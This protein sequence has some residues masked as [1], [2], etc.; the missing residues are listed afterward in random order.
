MSKN[1]SLYEILGVDKSASADE[2][3]KAYRKLARKYHPDINKDPGA[4]E[5]FKEIN[6]AYE[7]LGDEEKRRQY[8]TYGDSMFGGQNFSDFARNAGGA[9]LSDILKN[10]FG[11]AFSGGGFSRNGGFGGFNFDFGG[12]AED[13]DV[14]ANI[15]IPLYMAVNGGEREFSFNGENIKIKI[16]A[17]IGNGSKLRVKGKGKHS[18][19]GE[20]GNLILSIEI[21]KDPEYDIENDDLYKN[22]DIPLKIALFG[23][24]VDV[25]TLQKD[26]T[27]KISKNTKNGQKIRLKGYGILNPKTKIKGDLYLKVNVVLPD[28][29]KLD[30]EV[31]KILEEK[32]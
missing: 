31:V 20:V 7:V 13:L 1:E 16:P 18:S 9:D 17:G 26:V 30:S 3:K 15:K 22:I 10:I 12:F 19:R 14:N 23:G 32:L 4:E 28:V 6:G 5:K 21:E 11:G 2:I 25:E 27:I 29:D 8:D 24:K